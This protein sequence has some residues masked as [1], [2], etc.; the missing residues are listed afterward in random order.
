MG[1]YT[2]LVFKE[3]I[4]PRDAAKWE[5]FQIMRLMGW[6]YWEYQKAPA[7]LIK[8]IMAFIKTENKAMESIRKDNG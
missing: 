5:R 4:E 8:E 3:V 7:S 1:I 2:S 6:N